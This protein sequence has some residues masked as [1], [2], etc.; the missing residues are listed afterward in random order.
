[1]ENLDHYF[2]FARGLKGKNKKNNEEFLF[3]NENYHTKPKSTEF[4]AKEGG[5]TG[6]VKGRT[7]W[8]HPLCGESNQK[9]QNINIKHKNAI[10]LGSIPLGSPKRK[11]FLGMFYSN[12]GAYIHTPKLRS[13]SEL[14]FEFVDYREGHRQAVVR[15]GEGDGP[16]GKWRANHRHPEDYKKDKV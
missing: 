8:P 13:L 9:H 5:F 7:R 12:L 4:S 16:S 2:P 3:A 6:G 15:G 10:K 1:M 14:F 11:P